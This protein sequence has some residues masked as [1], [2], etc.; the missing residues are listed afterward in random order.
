MGDVVKCKAEIRGDWHSYQCSR[1]ATTP[2]GFCIQ[3]S[4]E[5]VAER[6]AKKRAKLDAERARREDCFERAARLSGLVEAATGLSAEVRPV[7]HHVFGWTPGVVE[8]SV[9]GLRALLAKVEVCDG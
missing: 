9:E 2:D 8:I 4:P 5:K 3:H 6:Q 7:H 1:N